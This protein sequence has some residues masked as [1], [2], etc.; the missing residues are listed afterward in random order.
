MSKNQSAIE[1]AKRNILDVVT[2]QVRSFQERGELHF[3]PNYSPENAIASGWLKILQTTDRN[4]RPVLEVCKPES[5]R[6][7]LLDMVIQ[8][9]S[10]V[11]NQCYFIPYG[12]KLDLIRSYHGTRAV[13]K[14]ITKCKDIFAEVVYEDDEFEYEIEDGNKRI[15]KHKQ[16]IKNIDKSKII[17]AYCTII[18][19]DYKYSEIMTFDEIKTA[20]RKSPLKPL[21]DKGN[22]RRGT[23]HDEF[24]QEMCKRTVTNR[25]CKM[26]INSSMDDNLLIVRSFNRA[27]QYQDEA[28]VE[29]EISEYA[30]K[31]VLDAE[32]VEHDAQEEQPPLPEPPAEKRSEKPQTQKKATKR[33]PDF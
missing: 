28:Q 4:N 30:N 8:G 16:S 1:V 5:V 14:S 22:L 17:A 18:F 33:G 32:F 21:D 24:T 29:D 3:P 2:T 11:K 6:E 13:T 7:A 31:E 26:Y 9:L 15:T 10:P 20:W 27:G 12:S 23:T 19:D 25:T